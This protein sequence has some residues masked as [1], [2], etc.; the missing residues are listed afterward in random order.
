M[1]ATPPPNASI[2]LVDDNKDGLVV[3]RSLLQELGY[4]VEISANAE[5][6]LTLLTSSRFDL[7]V[8]DHKM[9]RMDGTE[10]IERIR[11]V[12]PNA[13]VI[14]LSGFVEPLGLNEE[15]TGADT[16]ILKSVREPVHLVRAVKRLLNRPAPKK[17]P[18]TQAGGGRARTGTRENLAN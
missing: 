14:L 3:R 13:R 1:K 8:T 10:L 9:P 2:L 7:I 12:D 4:H 18:G 11:K 15:N 17:P 16:V 6:A 5:E